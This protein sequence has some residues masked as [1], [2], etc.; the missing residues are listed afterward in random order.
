MS[1]R[2]SNLEATH[3]RVVMCMIPHVCIALC[4]PVSAATPTLV[5]ENHV[6]GAAPRSSVLTATGRVG[7]TATCAHGNRR[8][9]RHPRPRRRHASWSSLSRGI[10]RSRV[11]T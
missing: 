11:P 8:R 9:R 2:H 7:I 5:V 4:V 6:P 3:M 10:A 1:D